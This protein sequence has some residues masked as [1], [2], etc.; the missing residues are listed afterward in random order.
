MQR[1]ARMK[2][3]L[4]LLEN[5]PPPGIS[6]W[7]VNDRIDNL[8]AN[9]LGGED[10]PYCGGIFKLDIHVPERYPF[11]P[12]KVQFITPIYHPNIDNAGRI[13]LDILKMPP[14]GAWKPSWNISTVLKSIQSLMAEP[15]PEDPLM[16]EISDQFKYH[17]QEFETSAKE[18]TEKHAVSNLSCARKPLTAQKITDS[19]QNQVKNCTSSSSGKDSLCVGY[20]NNNHSELFKANIPTKRMSNQEDST[21]PS[22][23]VKYTCI[24]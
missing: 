8:Q 7:M 21:Q 10:T 13:C 3:E 5:D 18:W 1:V 4:R 24:E 17:R 20:T 11:Q 19:S 2:R 16:A 6:C 9:I 12:P 14:K 15:N 22:K 23:L